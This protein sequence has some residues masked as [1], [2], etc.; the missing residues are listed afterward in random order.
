LTKKANYGFGGAGSDIFAIASGQGTV[1]IN[2][3]VD[4]IDFLG[5][6]GSLDFSDLNIVSDAAGTGSII[7]DLSNNNALVATIVNVSVTA[8]TQADFTIA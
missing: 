1:I 8:L 6:T 4:G 7:Y 2:D 5:F 3:F